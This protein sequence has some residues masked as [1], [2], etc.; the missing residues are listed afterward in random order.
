MHKLIL[1]KSDKRPRYRIHGKQRL[2]ADDFIPDSGVVASSFRASTPEWCWVNACCV[3]SGMRGCSFKPQLLMTGISWDW[4]WILIRTLRVSFICTPHIPHLPTVA[5]R[6]S[7]MTATPL[8]WPGGTMRENAGA[9]KAGRTLEYLGIFY[10][11]NMKWQDSTARPVTLIRDC[12][13]FNYF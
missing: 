11:F 3:S 12:M 9:S 10:K 5:T 4:Y 1:R 13:H 8:E 7:E 6:P 2:N